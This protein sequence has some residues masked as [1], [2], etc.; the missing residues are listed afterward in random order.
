MPNFFRSE[1]SLGTILEATI[2][3]EPIP[4]HRAAITLH[5]NDRLQAIREVKEMIAFDPA[6][7]EML[8]YNVLKK[9]CKNNMTGSCITG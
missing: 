4:K 1:G 2:N 7:I 8:D 9:N 6:A 5:Y 3:L